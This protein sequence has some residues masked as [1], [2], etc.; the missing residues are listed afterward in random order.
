MIYNND[1]LQN[2]AKL[3][4]SKEDEYNSVIFVISDEP[5]NKIVYDGINVPS[6]L[7]V[8]KNS[9]VVNSFSKSLALPG[10]RIG[11]IAVNSS[12]KEADLLVNAMVFC[13]RTLGFVNAPA[14]FQRVVAE[15]LDSGVNIEEYKKRRDIIYNHLINLGFSCVKPNGAFYLFPKSL[16]EDDVEFVKTAQKH[17][18]LLVP[19][20]GFGCPGHFRIAYCANIK[21]IENSLPA[22]EALAAEFNL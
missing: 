17:N 9:I 15:T 4:K 21:T 8:F 22:F 1:T 14:L 19:G 2:I 6:V 3:L 5:Y 10:E 16:I 18:I 20:K 7:K 13:N 11:Y 12:I